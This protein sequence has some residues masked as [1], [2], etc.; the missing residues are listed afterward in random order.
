MTGAQAGTAK[1]PYGSRIKVLSTT[2]TYPIKWTIA[3]AC[4]VSAWLGAK[5]GSFKMTSQFLEAA[6]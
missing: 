5:R 3:W 6:A 2:V 1:L 4:C